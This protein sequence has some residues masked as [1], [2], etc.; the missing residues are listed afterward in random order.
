MKILFRKRCNPLKPNYVKKCVA[1]FGESYNATVWEIISNSHKGIN[2]KI[3]FKNVATLLPNF[4]MTRAG[5]FKGVKYSGGIVHDPN[6]QI[7]ASWAGVGNKTIKLRNFLTSIRKLEPE[8]SLKY[9]V[10]CKRK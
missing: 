3:F 6:G 8:C 9:P 2:K 4:G 1:G 5:P 7:A 10:Q